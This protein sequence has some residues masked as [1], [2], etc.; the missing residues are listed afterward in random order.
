MG[1]M[2]TV[3]RRLILGLTLVAPLAGAQE[4]PALKSQKEKVSYGIGVDIA[5]NLKRQGI[6]ID[7]ELLVRG[8]RDG[9]P[10]GKLLI[11]EEDLR[12][13]VTA[14]QTELMQKRAHEMKVVA[15]ENRKKGDAFL[16]QNGKAQGVVTMPSGLQ[17]KI[18]RLGTGRTPTEADTV[19]VSYRGMHI[20]GTEFNATEVGKP[21]T[22]QIKGGLIP[23]WTEALQ[24]MPVGSKFLF[25][26]PSQLGYGEKGAGPEIG[27]NETLIFEVEL[28]AIK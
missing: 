28:L 3:G 25:V 26:I 21:A 11:P 13:I 6:E 5:R 1:R 2:M 19:E 9:S 15:E 18:L 16:A 14:F 27:P 4:T 7:L 24:L 12:G 23:G 17:Y 20:D 8:I 22:L 10:G